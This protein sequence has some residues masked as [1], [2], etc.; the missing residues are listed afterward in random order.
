MPPQLE[1]IRR[2]AAEQGWPL[3]CQG[4]SGEETVIRLRISPTAPWEEYYGYFL[5]PNTQYGNSVSFY[6]SGM[7][8]PET[9]DEPPV[10]VTVGPADPSAR[11]RVR[12]G[13]LAVGE[14]AR[15]ELLAALA[16][17][18]GF[19]DATIRPFED[20]DIVPS[21]AT[22]SATWQSLV[23]QEGSTLRYGPTG[24]F[25]QLLRDAMNEDEVQRD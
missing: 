25:V 24:C 12:P 7:E 8:V 20:D 22:R 15:M 23:I 2:L 1:P 10:V 14:R 6:Y 17:A 13:L 5:D 18:C 3:V 16:M 11:S 9:C 19:T 4:R 21:P